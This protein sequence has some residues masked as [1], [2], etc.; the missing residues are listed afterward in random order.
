MSLRQGASISN[1]SLLPMTCATASRPWCIEESVADDHPA[2]C[3]DKIRVV[4]ATRHDEEAFRT[5]SALERSLALYAMFDF[6]ERHLFPNNSAGLP[7]V[8]NI[9]LGEAKD[10]PRVLVFVHDPI[11]IGYHLIAT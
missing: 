11:V 2:A 3:A 8:Y 7:A 5:Q 9:A 4:C 10:A 1:C 6:L